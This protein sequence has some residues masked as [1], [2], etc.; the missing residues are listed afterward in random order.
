[1]RGP[2]AG[3]I[4]VVKS[5]T[6]RGVCAYCGEERKLTRDHVP[7]RSLFS[8]P[9]PNNLI[10]VPSCFPCNNGTSKDDEYF[11]LVVKLGIDKER[12]PNEH[13]DSIATLKKLERPGSR[14]FA[15]YLL[16]RYERSPSGLAGFRIERDRI[17]SVLHRF[18]R[19]LFYH[20]AMSR[21][22]ESVSFTFVSLVDQPKKAAR[23]K[24]E[25]DNLTRSLQTIG[26]GVFR[27]AF[28]GSLSDPFITEWLLSFYDHRS[29]FCVTGIDLPRGK[30]SV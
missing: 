20:H 2:I 17:G 3:K 26:G 8:E 10:T 16:Q 21:I 1:M 6:E 14:G 27:Y 28:L 12:F 18:V 5:D 9:R 11:N 30:K 4:G 24:D 7:S 25:I 22:P 19:G 23:L 15:N 13:A 29:F